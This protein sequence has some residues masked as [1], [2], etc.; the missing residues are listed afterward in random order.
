MDNRKNNGAKV[1]E[2]RGQGRK[3]KATEIELIEMLSPLDAIAFKELAKGVKAGKFP[4][5]KLF[6]EYRYGKAKQQIEVKAE[7]EPEKEFDWSKL[8][9]KELEMFCELNRKIGNN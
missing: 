8:S 1:G 9:D 3:S 6:F 5:I 4:Y 7:V 2:D